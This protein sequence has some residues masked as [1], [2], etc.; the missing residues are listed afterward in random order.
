MRDVRLRWPWRGGHRDQGSLCFQK[1]TKEG[2]RLH[3]QK[4]QAAGLQRLVASSH[5]SSNLGEGEATGQP[6]S[7]SYDLSNR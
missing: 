5:S 4:S 3:V 6:A 7:A 1:A 2:T